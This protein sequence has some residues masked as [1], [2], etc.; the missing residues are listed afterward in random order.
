[1]KKAQRLKLAA[2]LMGVVCLSLGVRAPVLAADCESFACT[3]IEDT[4]ERAA[5][6]DDK[7]ACY[8]GLID[9]SQE[10]Q[11]T[12]QNAINNIDYQVKLQ[13]AEIEA[14]RL[15]ILR[16]EKEIEVLSGRIDN[17]NASM[18]QLSQILE[19]LVVTSYKT[20]KVS[21]LEMYLAADN[22]NDGVQ[23]KEQEEMAS[24]QTSILL[25][26]AM[27]AKLTFD[28]QKL[29]REALQEELQDKTAYLERQQVALE[30]QKAEKT[31]LL[32]QTQNDEA[33]YQRLLS[34]AQ[35]EADSFS[36]FASSAG[37]GTCLGSSPTGGSNG[38]FYSQRD[39]RWCNQYIGRS[40]MTVGEVGCYLTAVTMIHKKNG[41]STTPSIMAANNNYYF[42]NTA[43][44]MTPP[45]PAGLTYRR[46]DYFN[47]GTIDSELAAG[48]PVIVH[49]SVN[50]GYG[51]HF[52]VLTEG[53]GGSYTMHDPWY[54]ADL[55][56]SSRYSTGMIT[57]VRVFN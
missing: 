10:E 57:S 36:R 15:D 2:I 35:A 30:Q 13:E 11:D 55:S 43:L 56:F 14:T 45:A 19:G 34:D 27:D 32:S 44:M 18:D 12:L 33:T 42:S 53:G 24:I 52:I 31:I 46:Y 48:R 4:D 16:T 21:S 23:S 22:F 28:Q 9:Q 6:V 37:G 5:C 39:P 41:V 20:T 26:E 1:M 3:A 7:V 50:N 49:V 25:F 51:G 47:M 29:E 17:L 54:G 40:Y 8:Q 38:Y